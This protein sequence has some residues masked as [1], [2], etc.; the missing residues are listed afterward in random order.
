MKEFTILDA[1]RADI[2]FLFDPEDIPAHIGACDDDIAEF[3]DRHHD[4]IDTIPIASI[5]SAIKQMGAFTPEELEEKSERSSREFAL[6]LAA[7]DALENRDNAEQID[8]FG[9]VGA[10]LSTY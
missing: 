2:Y 3:Y 9:R 8:E 1:D 5:K 10:N 7:N 6:W 4:I